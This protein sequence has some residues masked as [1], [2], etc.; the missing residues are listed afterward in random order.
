MTSKSPFINY[1]MIWSFFVDIFSILIKK[2][3]KI[4]KEM[5]F[6]LSPHTYIPIRP[7]T[8]YYYSTSN[9]DPVK[10]YGLFIIIIRG[11]TKPPPRLYHVIITKKKK[12]NGSIYLLS[13]SSHRRIVI[14]VVVFV[15]VSVHCRFS[16][17]LNWMSVAN[18]WS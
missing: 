4:E 16:L 7:L 3:K 12:K 9:N 8:S 15:Y 11:K 18:L 17:C 13:A 6:S 14:V 10:Y 2:E 5:H 1:N